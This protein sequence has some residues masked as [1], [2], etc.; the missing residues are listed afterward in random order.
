M[1][2]Q[3]LKFAMTC[4]TTQRILLT[5]LLNSFSQSIKSRGAGF[6]IG[7]IMS[8]PTYP[9]SPI[10]FLGFRVRRTPDSARQYVSWRLPSI[11]SEIQARCPERVHATCTFTPVVLCL[12]EYSSGC[13]AHDQQGSRV[14]STMY[15]LRSSRSSAVGTYSAST[16]PNAGVTPV[17]AG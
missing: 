16:T 15:W 12:P 9:L 2:L 8:L 11:A 13:D 5:C 14:P 1:I 10:Q 17:T 4:S 7:V 6:L 3:V